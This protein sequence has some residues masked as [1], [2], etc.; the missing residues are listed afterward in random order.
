VRLLTFDNITTGQVLSNM[1]R[2]HTLTVAA[3]L[4]LI[5]FTVFPAHAQE[6]RPDLALYPLLFQRKDAP[7]NPTDPVQVLMVGDTSMARG[8]ETVT[9]VN[10]MDYP[11]SRVSPWLHAADLTVGNYEG[12]IA[13]DNVG[14]MRVPGY[15]LRAKPEVAAALM[16]GGFNVLNL[17]NNHTMDWGPDSLQSTLEHLHGVGIQ[18][19]GAGPTGP[20]ARKPVVTTVR[21]VKIVWLS[22]TMVPDHPGWNS[23]KEKSWSRSWFGPTFARDRLAAMVKDA[24]PLGDVLIVQFH[25]GNEY[26]PCPLDWQLDLART[27]IRSGASLVVGHHPHIVQP[28]ETF[29]NGFIAYS[30]GNFL[31]D[32]PMDPGLALWIRLDKQGVIDV[33]GLPVRP[34]VRPEWYT[35]DKAASVLYGL[36]RLSAP[37]ATSFGYVGGQ[38][39]A[40]AAPA[41]KIMFPGDLDACTDHPLPTREIGQIDMTGDGIPERI[42]LG[43]GTLRVFKGDQEVYA[44]HP[45]WQVV[46]ASVGDPNHDG[47][48]EALLLLWKQDQPGAPVTT[49]PFILG[50]RNG[51][52]KVIWGGSA[53]TAWVQAVAVGDVDGD[54]LDE[55]V[56][57][58]RDP[59]ALPCD[60]RY[61]IVVMKWNGWG[62]TRQWSSD[63]SR[64]DQL[65]LLRRDDLGGLLSIVAR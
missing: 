37:R 32:Q 33:H 40:L 49:H 48:F 42:T 9:G 29:L 27:A 24:Q 13:A 50:H 61:R 11:L 62:F 41:K 8:V 45:S 47:R 64:F 14:T 36:C 56:T 3:I 1:N 38:Y 21:G 12:V 25:W 51:E 18:T 44:S 10:G 19:I 22:F 2:L 31:F 35:P 57:V 26:I 34:G 60:Q 15:R 6:S 43:K 54:S 59:D 23:D 53:T 46:D 17:A 7:A 4:V 28:Y 65:T 52:Y 39:Q 5:P 16:R 55:L 58:E 30:L 20:E 63:Y